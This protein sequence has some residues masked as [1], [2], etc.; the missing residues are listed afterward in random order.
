[1]REFC[2]TSCSKNYIKESYD[3]AITDDL[4]KNDYLIDNKINTNKL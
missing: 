3:N 1:M 2:S 4:I